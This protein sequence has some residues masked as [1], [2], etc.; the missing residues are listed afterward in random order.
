MLVA[1]DIGIEIT[2]IQEEGATFLVLEKWD[3]RILNEASQL[4]FAH[5]KIRSGLLR[6]E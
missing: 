3:D 5:R 4:P 1:V 6:A 2:H